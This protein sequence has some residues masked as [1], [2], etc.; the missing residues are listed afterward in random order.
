MYN[1]NTKLKA[2]TSLDAK[3]NRKTP[4][5]KKLERKMT[6]LNM[7]QEIEVRI[8]VRAEQQ[9]KLHKKKIL[10]LRDK[11]SGNICAKN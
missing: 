4:T 11:I 2:G 10:I 6:R 1:I 8:M 7:R 5:T 9:L 3:R